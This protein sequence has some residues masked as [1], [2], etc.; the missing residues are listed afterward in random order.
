M[1]RPS[2]YTKALATKI[3]KQMVEGKSLRTICKPASMPNK[4]TIMLWVSTDREGFSDQ[5]AKAFDARMLFHADELLD[6]A[7]DGQNDYVESNDPNN[8]GY[9]VNGEAIARS[10]LRVDT[11]KWLM[12][13]LINRYSDKNEENTSA[14]KDIADA[15][16]AIAD[17]LPS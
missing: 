16:N 13:K 14:A 15:M 11:R 5:Y 2:K 10:R 3:C 8:D 12:C 7:D 1:A 17:K 9:R 6:I 4:S